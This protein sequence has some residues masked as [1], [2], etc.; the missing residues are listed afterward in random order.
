MTSSSSEEA[1]AIERVQAA[2]EKAKREHAKLM[3]FT[4][5]FTTPR[6]GCQAPPSEASEEEAEEYSHPPYIIVHTRPYCD[7]IASVAVSAHIAI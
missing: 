6:D 3:R 7:I 4:V 5:D 1:A 2:R